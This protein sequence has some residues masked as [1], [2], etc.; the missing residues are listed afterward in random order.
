MQDLEAGEDIGRDL[1][2]APPSRCA[3]RIEKIIADAVITDRACRALQQQ[4]RVHPLR[5]EH[6]RQ[7]AQRTGHAVEPQDVAIDDKEAVVEQRQGVL[8]PATGFEQFFLARQ[9]DVRVAALRE[10]AGNQV[11][12]VV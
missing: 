5:V 3:G 2:L 8:Y 4:E 6:L 9:L 1:A 11:G 12:L 10:P 7:P